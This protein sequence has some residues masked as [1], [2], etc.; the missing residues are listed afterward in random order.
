V[1]KTAAPQLDVREAAAVSNKLRLL[2]VGCSAIEA[3]L[4]GLVEEGARL[5]YTVAKAHIY[6][7]V[8]NENVRVVVPFGMT[9]ESVSGKGTEKRPLAEVSVLLGL[10]YRIALD[11]WEPDDD[12]RIRHFAGISGYMHAWPYVRAEVQGLS[13]KLGLPA[14]TLPLLVSGRAAELVNASPFGE[15]PPNSARL[16][17][18]TKASSKKARRREPT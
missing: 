11:A 18:D 14:L 16:G 13:V 5:S 12:R 15:P 3:K 17:P 4:V 8:A 2:R 6:Y 9:I 10:D 1:K 7:G